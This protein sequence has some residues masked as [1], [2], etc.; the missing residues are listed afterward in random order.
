MALRKVK[1][2]FDRTYFWYLMCELVK[3]CDLKKKE[4]YN[5]YFYETKH[6][7]DK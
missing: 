3:H 5:H 4:D 6:Q 7:L 1:M 2:D